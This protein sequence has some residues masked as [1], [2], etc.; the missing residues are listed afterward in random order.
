[1]KIVDKLKETSTS[2]SFEFF[3]PKTEEAKNQLFNTIKELQP[4]NPTFVSVTY[5][6]GG[7]TREKTREVVKKI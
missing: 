4:L 3:P 2:I 1:M 5:G 7:S 6:A